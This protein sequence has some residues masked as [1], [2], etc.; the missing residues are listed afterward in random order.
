[1]SIEY[2][3]FISHVW[4]STISV[5][6][7]NGKHI[8]SGIA[9]KL[10]VQIHFYWVNNSC[11]QQQLASSC[12]LAHSLILL[13]CLSFD[14]CKVFKSWKILKMRQRRNPNRSV[15][16]A[17]CI[18]KKNAFS[19]IHA[20]IK[21]T[22]LTWSPHNNRNNRKTYEQESH[23][24]LSLSLALTHISISHFPSTCN[25]ERNIILYFCYFKKNE[26][27]SETHIRKGISSEK[28][29]I[30][31][32]EME[33]KYHLGP[34]RMSAFSHSPHLCRFYLSSFRALHS[35]MRFPAVSCRTKY[36]DFF[37]GFSFL[38]SLKW[39][40]E[41]ICMR[42]MDCVLPHC[43]DEDEIIVVELEQSNSVPTHTHSPHESSRQAK[44]IFRF[45]CSWRNG[46][47]EVS[48]PFHI[49]HTER[50]LTLLHSHHRIAFHCLSTFLRW[51]SCESRQTMI[52]FLHLKI[53]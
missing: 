21:P 4:Q 6:L 18:W 9:E 27:S 23:Q 35:F 1:M 29:V 20:A 10:N 15:I 5:V 26:N 45:F 36:S 25:V 33:R 24:Q 43:E 7:Q 32:D 49:L 3:P 2:T 51:I 13:C 41:R 11:G 50:A 22:R 34:E 47:Y 19:P 38:F 39:F 42:R 40:M 14:D 53:K 44:R 31:P 48:R 17:C 12:S 16:V 52:R 30:D 37:L 46:S 8:L 28:I